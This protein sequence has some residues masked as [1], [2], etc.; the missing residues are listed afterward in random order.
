MGR[1][2][3]HL[4]LLLRS[5]FLGVQRSFCPSALSLS[6]PLP[7]QRGVGEDGRAGA[8]PPGGCL[9][10][11]SGADVEPEGCVS[12]LARHGCVHCS[13]GCL[14]VSTHLSRLRGWGCRSR[15]VRGWL[16]SD[17]GFPLGWMAMNGKRG[18]LEDPCSV[19]VMRV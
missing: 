8:D 17:V 16:R 6:V 18:V 9:H 15:W 4:G 11:C 13:G 19:C 3:H 1:G 10:G 5:Y 2:L 14:R 12:L 7:L